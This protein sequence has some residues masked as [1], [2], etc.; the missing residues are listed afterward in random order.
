MLEVDPAV[1]AAPSLLRPCQAWS[2]P[3]GSSGPGRYPQQLDQRHLGKSNYDD[4]RDGILFT[5]PLSVLLCWLLARLFRRLLH[6]LLGFSEG[7][8]LGVV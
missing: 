4:L 3:P 7:C 6:R 8:P 5:T 1:P 2:E